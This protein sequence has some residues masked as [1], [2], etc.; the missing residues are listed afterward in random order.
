MSPFWLKHINS[1]SRTRHAG[2][3]WRS[4]DEL[5]S[6]VLLWIP[7]YGQTKAGR[8]AQTYIQQ[9]CDDTGCNPEDLPEAMNN[10]ETW[11][12]GQGY[13]CW[14]QDMMMMM[15]PIVIGALCT[16]TKGLNQELEFLELNVETIQTTVLFRSARILRRILETWGDLP[17][18]KPRVKNHQV[19]LVR[20]TLNNINNNNCNISLQPH[21]G[22]NVTINYRLQM[23]FDLLPASSHGLPYP[24][25]SPSLVYILTYKHGLRYWQNSNTKCTIIFCCIQFVFLW[26]ALCHRREFQSIICFLVFVLICISIHSLIFMNTQILSQ[27]LSLSL[28]LSLSCVSFSL[29]LSRNINLLQEF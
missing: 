28:S 14:P 15:I 17:S 24:F 10:R 9:L 13:P 29:S 27:S 4:K 23:F 16:V 26:F 5:V 25:L 12:E 1:A 22:F 8:P 19:T 21:L 18:L 20:K 7:A 11:G 3:C 6:D 2:H